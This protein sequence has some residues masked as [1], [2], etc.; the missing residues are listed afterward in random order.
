MGGALVF[1]FF[2]SVV[3]GD[4]EMWTLFSPVRELFSPPPHCVC[5]HRNWMGNLVRCLVHIQLTKSMDA[6]WS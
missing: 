2:L 1:F 6:E 3:V 5:G 4:S